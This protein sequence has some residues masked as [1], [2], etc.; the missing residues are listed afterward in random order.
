MFK[1]VTVS[2]SVLET[3][4]ENPNKVRTVIIYIGGS[5]LT[6]IDFDSAFSKSVLYRFYIGSVTVIP[7]FCIAF[8]PEK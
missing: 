7:R 6:R 4:M 8:K 5:V 2:V 1:T 3:V